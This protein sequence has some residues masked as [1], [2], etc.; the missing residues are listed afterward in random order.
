MECRCSSTAQPDLHFIAVFQSQSANLTNAGLD[1]ISKLLDGADRQ[2][3]QA[4]GQHPQNHDK[5]TEP[6]TFGWLSVSTLA[7]TKYRTGQQTCGNQ[8]ESHNTSRAGFEWQTY[9]PVHITARKPQNTHRGHQVLCWCPCVPTSCTWSLE[10][11]ALATY[12]RN[13]NS[14]TM[15]STLHVKLQDSTELPCAGGG[16][17]AGSSGSMCRKGAPLDLTYGREVKLAI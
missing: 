14:G 2:M 11:W 1:R 4:S 15:H 16:G 9:N 5:F 8:T 17:A 12:N 10:F 3:G 7:K 13:D 6:R